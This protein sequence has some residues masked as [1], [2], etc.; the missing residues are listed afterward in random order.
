MTT[1]PADPEP[2]STEGAALLEA[3]YPLEAVELLRQGV[4]SGE[5]AAPDLLFRAYLESGNWHAAAEWLA[6]LVAQGHVRFAGRL[7][8]AL[9]DAVARLHGG[10]FEL[11][12]ARPGLVGRILLPS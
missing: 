5:P 7:G 12:D 4:A 9:V 3:G 2:L 10:R 11:D 1:S 6:P 8:M